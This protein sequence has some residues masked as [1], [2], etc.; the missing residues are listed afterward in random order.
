[1]ATCEAIHNSWTFCA[2]I[3]AFLDLA[4]TYLMLCGAFLAFFASKFLS[5][6]GFSLP[7]PCNGLFGN[8][9][10]T[11]CVQTLL[12]EHPVR[13]MSSLQLSVKNK[14]P[15]D[16]VFAKD[17]NCVNVKL[18]RDRICDDRRMNGVE[19]DGEASC[20]SVSEA[21]I[22]RNDQLGFRKLGFDVKGKG[23]VNY[24]RM[25]SGV[26]RRRKVSTDCGKFVRGFSSD[27]SISDGQ[28]VDNVGKEIDE[29][30]LE[31]NGFVVG[32]EAPVAVRLDERVPCDF[33]SYEHVDEK[34]LS[35]KGSSSL[36]RLKYSAPGEKSS[37]GDERNA[38]R[39][40]EQA[41]EEEHV[42]RAALYLELEKERSA[43][44]S[45][46][47]EAMAMILR[48]QEEKASIEMETRQY[49]RMIEEKS[50]Y[51]AE[52]MNILKEILVRRER[53][54]HFLE[55]E[56]E[57]YRHMMFEGNVQLEGEIH[58]MTHGQEQQ[59][60]FSVH[61]G[62]DPVVMLQHLST[63]NNEKEKV[64]NANKS[65]DAGN[66]SIKKQNV[67]LSFGKELPIPNWD[68][69]AAEF[70]KSDILAPPSIDKYH[71]Q[72]LGCDGEC[73]QQV[74]EKGMLFEDGS[75]TQQREVHKLVVCPELYE[76][77]NG[78]EHTSLEKTITLDAEQHEQS[79]VIHLGAGQLI[80][81]LNTRDV[82]EIYGP[83]DVANLANHCQD[84]HQESNDLCSSKNEK[85]RCIYD[86]HIVDDESNYH[87]DVSGR[88]S[89][90]N[91]MS[92]VSNPIKPVFPS[93]VAELQTIDVLNEGPT[94]IITESEP[95]MNRSSS[96]MTNGF[97]PMGRSCLSTFLSGM[98][99]NSMSAAGLERS[100]LDSEVEWLQ[101]RLKV[102]QEGR[103]KLNFS[104][105]HKEGEM[106]QLQ[107]LED[108]ARQL[109]EIRHLT[110]PRKAIRQASLPPRYSK[111][112]SKKRRWR[113]VSLELDQS[114]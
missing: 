107:I 58:D 10:T 100:K 21:R 54:K 29:E 89:I 46:A 38:I 105:E 49:Q 92:A 87:A 74:E 86:V 48:L 57:S 12:V 84:S 101:E 39:M 33:E 106:V 81:S 104:M 18:I 72:V 75:A 32:G 64:Y 70:L 26:R 67:T 7:C 85:E 42:A 22:S 3:G 34:N 112:A 62:E 59:L 73:N 93:E 63:T 99:R 60:D 88:K 68:E 8:P 4:L 44:A 69:D 91:Q 83:D 53:E 31:P 95:E 78:P 56:V 109:R 37:D 11:S 71:Q 61:S 98:R 90:P 17:P 94:T 27:R 77:T 76:S 13:K 97:P 114:T 28:N 50:A 51:D 52:E 2:L 35:E 113:S 5:I 9:N 6:F 111:I 41:L 102:V 43:A 96:D 15:F 16:S 108:I 55:N 14:F 82:S 25:R 19:F 20:S 80:K 103:E 47:D 66:A 23:V 1:M 79:D 40:L 30:K 45:A 110:D 36:E 65:M 24:Q